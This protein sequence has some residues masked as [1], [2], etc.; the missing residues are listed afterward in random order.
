MFLASVTVAMDVGWQTML[1][2]KYFLLIKMYLLYI[3]AFLFVEKR[4][5]DLIV[6]NLSNAFCDE[7]LIK[8]A[9]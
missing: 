8:Y 7:Q 5:K 1:R 9:Q 6:C 4:V 3:D 2:S